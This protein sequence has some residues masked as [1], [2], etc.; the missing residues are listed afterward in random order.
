MENTTIKCDCHNVELGSYDNQ[1]VLKAP[2]WSSHET[3]CVDTCVSKE[4][5]Q[6]W[7]MG[8]ITYGCCCGHNVTESMVNVDDK[9]IDKMLSM[10]YVQNHSDPT[11]KDTFRLKSAG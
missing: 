7:E 4:I 8:I 2:V 1:V 11:R 3:I 9:D 6:L 10:G 5:C